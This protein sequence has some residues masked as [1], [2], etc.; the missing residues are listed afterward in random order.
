MV[1]PVANKQAY[2]PEFKEQPRLS[3]YAALFNSIEINSSF[4]KVP[5]ATTVKKWAGLVPV[6]FK[7]TYKLWREIT[8]NKGLLFDPA[9]VARFINVINET[10]D[11]KGSLL[12][13][14]P[15]SVKA[16]SLPQVMQLLRIIRE[17]DPA[18]QWHTAVEF[19][20]HS[21]YQEKTYRL[22]DEYR[23]GMVLHDLPASATP[24][25]ETDVDFI[26]LRFHGPNGGY[27]DSYSDDFLQEYA[28]KIND[29]LY[30][31]KT[32]YAYFNNTM[33]AAVHN[34]ATLNN[35]IKQSF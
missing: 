20:H 24:L 30:D 5:M 19:R 13:Q 4:Y 8:H 17:L 21:W 16:D 2:P 10:G 32:V 12:V 27:R 33:G 3:Y 7:F 1:L 18:L 31:G 29:W 25:M 35:M 6:D 14:F 11:K 9:E 22:L 23:A 26:Y 28:E 34:L 15:P